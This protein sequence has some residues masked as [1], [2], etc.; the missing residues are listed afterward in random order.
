MTAAPGLPGDGEWTVNDLSQLP[1]DLRYELIDGRLI[2]LPSPTFLHQELCFQ[3][4]IMLRQNC[5][6]GWLPGIDISLKVDIRNEPRP[7]VLVADPRR[8]RRS[9][10]PIEAAHLVVEI[11]SPTSHRRDLLDK[12]RLYARAGV[13]SYWVIHPRGDTLTLTERQ[14]ADDGYRI[15][16]ETDG[17]FVTD[18]PWKVSI[19]LPA[20]SDSV[21][22]HFGDPED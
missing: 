3:L 4:A 6:R 5:P 1:P 17:L 10:L 20:L 11:V 12:V 8:G 9:P 13:Q 2:H 22:D 21:R 16:A 19:D 18:W 7:D 15:T 14:L